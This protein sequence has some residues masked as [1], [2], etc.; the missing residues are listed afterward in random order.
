MEHN[1]E[2]V[3]IGNEEL[4]RKNVGLVNRVND[5]EREI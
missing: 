4:V 5:L 2:A 1:Q 3:V